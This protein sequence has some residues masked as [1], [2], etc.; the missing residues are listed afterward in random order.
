MNNVQ[1]NKKIA[2]FGG[3]FNPPTIAHIE[4]AKMVVEKCELD[5]LYFVPVGNFYEKPEL[6]DIKH[7]IEMLKRAIGNCSKLKIEDLEAK[8]NHKLYA[9]DVFK[10]LKEKYK[11]HDIFFVMGEDNYNDLS[12]W[13]NYQ[14]LKENYKYIIIEREKDAKNIKNE[15]IIFLKNE[16]FKNISSN[17]IRIQ[18]EDRK[19]PES[20][21]NNDVW[22][23]IKEKELYKKH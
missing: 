13:K 10:L 15:K 3:C 2:F 16:N 9:I 21:A 19:K 17:K 20:I 7:R 8:Y 14:E 5:E 4:I 1:K 22:R 18:I 11:N 12:T 6:I 23:Y